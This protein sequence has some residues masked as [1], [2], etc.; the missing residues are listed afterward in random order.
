MDIILV[1]TN[2][3][4]FEELENSAEHKLAVRKQI[5]LA[6]SNKFATNVIIISEFFSFLQKFFDRETAETRAKN[7]L[8]SD[9]VEFL[10]LGA[11]TVKK[12]AKLARDFKL[13]INDALIA[14][15]AIDVG[16]SVFTDNLKDFG[17]LGG[18]LKV[19]PLR[20]S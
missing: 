20:Q 12:A 3:L 2:I 14:Q 19:H 8:A 10:N 18:V 9:S 13:A 15:Q 17:K 7:L 1:D 5:E 4:I 6:V 16:A 11:D